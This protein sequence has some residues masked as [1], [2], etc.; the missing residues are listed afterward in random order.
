MSL[1]GIGPTGGGFG[2]GSIEIINV[3][4]PLANI[5]GAGFQT[6]A[7]FTLEGGLLGNGNMVRVQAF[8]N[9]SAGT[10]NIISRL[11]YGS[12]SVDADSSS[13]PKVGADGYIFAQDSD[14]VQQLKTGPMFA[15]G[16]YGD[17]ASAE[18]SSGDLTV[19][20]SID[21]DTDADIFV[22]NYFI[23]YLHRE[24]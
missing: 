5:T 15:A 11:T 24:P 16:A 4:R 6:I 9:R 1:G 17:A 7:S 8:L 19:S 12:T 14:S 13:V 3:Q 20:L 2:A 10:G 21:L 22:C 18:D 23:A